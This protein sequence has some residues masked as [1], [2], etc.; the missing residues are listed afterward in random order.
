MARSKDGRSSGRE[1]GSGATTT[2]AAPGALVTSA[3]A[4]R[5][6]PNGSN[7][8]SGRRRRSRRSRR[9]KLAGRYLRSAPRAPSVPGGP[10]RAPPDLHQ[11]VH[12][13][14]KVATRSRWTARTQVAS[15]V[16]VPV[17][18]R[19]LAIAAW[20]HSDRA[21][22]A[23]RPGPPR[24]GTIEQPCPMANLRPGPPSARSRATLEAARARTG[25]KAVASTAVARWSRTAG[26]TVATPTG[27]SEAAAPKRSTRTASEEVARTAAVRW[28]PTAS[29]LPTSAR[30][31]GLA[32]RMG[33][34]PAGTTA[35]TEPPRAISAGRVVTRP[36]ARIAARPIPRGSA[37]PTR[38]DPARAYDGAT[39]SCG[40]RSPTGRRAPRG[41]VLSAR[42]PTSA[43]PRQVAA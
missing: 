37:G 28:G 15:A 17:E 30:A 20:M 14:R 10:R 35:A 16:T 26:A 4:L 40:T 19:A 21:A 38:P 7:G 34:L 42:A 39:S 5:P 36:S 11:A 2:E 27:P 12:G 22:T 6:R 31:A 33:A 25:T 23:R 43:L 9:P 41:A 24:S 8:P 29:T 1:D 32:A 18:A 13:L 3:D